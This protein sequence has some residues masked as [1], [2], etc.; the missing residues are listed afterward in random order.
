M[1]MQAHW[2][3][4][5]VTKGETGVSW[6]QDAPLP[7]LELIALTGAGRHCAIIDV[8]GGASRLVDALLSRGFTD[9]TVLDLST[10][11]LGA[12]K[13]RIGAAA[14]AAHWLAEDATA[15]EPSRTYDV[16]HDRAAFHFLTDAADQAAYMARL[17]RALRP[18]GHVIIGTFAPDGPEKCSG[19]LVARHDAGSLGRALGADF[20]LLDARRHDHLTPWGATQRFQ[21]STFRRR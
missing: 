17:R 4:V 19:L 8:G 20:A 10:A 12:A 9:L 11:A 2:E 18:G 14:Q 1:S 6:F 21:F 16:W 13:A 7:S 3:N 5:Y 15:W